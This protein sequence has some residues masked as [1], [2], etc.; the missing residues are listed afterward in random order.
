MNEKIMSFLK[1]LKNKKM[2]SL[3]ELEKLFSGDITYEVFADEINKFIEANILREVKEHGKNN[4]PMPLAN[5]YRL[6]KYALK[7]GFIDEIQRLQLKVHEDIN[8]SLFLSLREKQWEK[9]LPYIEMIDGYLKKNGLP[10]DRA[11]SQE[12]SFHLVKDEKWID[13]G[14]GKALL[15]RVGIWNKLK[16]NNEP[17]PLMLAVNPKRFSEPKHKHLIVENKATYYGLLDAISDTEFT[18]LIYGVGWKIISS[19]SSMEKQLSLEDKEHTLYYFGDIDY[20][21]I[22]IWNSLKEKV[23][24]KPAVSFYKELLKKADARGKESQNRNQ[25]ALNNFFKFFDKKSKEKIR[26][27]L[28]NRGYYPQEG[29]NKKELQ[30][31]WRKSTWE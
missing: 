15:E 8:L 1:S 24:A 30:D 14:G 13:E 4:K 19:I 26:D 16:I 25:K 18:S 22:A 11:T 31:I 17:D 29:L 27:I 5:T 6:N 21:G 7:K 28:Q 12:R 10:T 2:V 9:D 23:A 3:G 20:E